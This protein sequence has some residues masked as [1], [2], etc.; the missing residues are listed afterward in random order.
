LLYEGA[1]IAKAPESKSPGNSGARNWSLV[2]R[3]ERL[4]LQPPKTRKTS[5]KIQFHGHITELVYQGETAIVMIRL[6]DGQM[7]TARMNTRAGD[8]VDTLAI[9]QQLTVAIDKKDMIII[10]GEA[11]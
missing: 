6:K 8:D 11:R 3:P 4:S 1:K 10:P 2:I 5:S 9:G 7:L